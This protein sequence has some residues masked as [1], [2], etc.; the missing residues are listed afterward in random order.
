MTLGK[1]VEHLRPP[2]ICM[3]AP[4]ASRT[5]PTT[6]PRLR[7]KVPLMSLLTVLAKATALCTSR[8]TCARVLFMG[9]YQQRST[10]APAQATHVM[11]PAALPPVNRHG[12]V[13]LQHPPEA[14]LTVEPVAVVT[15]FAVVNPRGAALWGD[16]HTSV[17]TWRQ[18]LGTG[19]AAS[20]RD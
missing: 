15:H 8:T 11:T 16:M 19:R 6:T 20:T 18:R 17:D 2:F 7:Q 5:A 13:L 12:P 9:P 4:S 10:F 3:R 14:G 1:Y